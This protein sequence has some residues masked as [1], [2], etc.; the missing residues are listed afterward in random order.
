[1][2]RPSLVIW[3]LFAAGCAAVVGYSY[4]TRMQPA[5]AELAPK[6]S[7]LPSGPAPGNGESWVTHA[8]PSAAE[9]TER[10]AAPASADPVFQLAT[11]VSSQDAAT[12][13]AAIS[14][15]ATAPPKQAISVLQE[16]LNSGD[17]RVDRPLALSSLR[18]MALNHGDGD[19]RIRNAIR[20]AIQNGD[21][22]FVREAEAVLNEIESAS[23]RGEPAPLH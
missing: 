20:Y 13:A 21:A 15:L 14:A 22:A 3:G 4:V 5:V 12:R 9:E 2:I 10:R 18:E 6:R 1:M 19:N 23:S 11:D 7:T 16:V 8:A 17:P